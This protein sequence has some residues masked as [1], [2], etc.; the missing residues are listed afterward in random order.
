MTRALRISGWTL[1]GAGLTILLYLVYSLFF[2]NFTTRTAQSEMLEQW[3]LE[4]GELAWGGEPPGDGALPGAEDPAD[5]GRPMAD[6]EP[7]TAF[8]VMRFERPGSAEPPVRA[9]PLFVVSGVT[10]D[11]L[12]R[13]PGHYPGTAS[14]GEPGNFAVAGHRTT[15]GAPFFHLDQLEAGDLV[16]VADRAG[17]AY[18]YELAELR[19]VGPSDTS[20]IG[21]DPLGNGRPTLTLTTCHPRFSNRERLIAFAQLVEEEPA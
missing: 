12:T 6:L 10:Y 14:P 8:A 20:V 2:T 7:G 4:V 1:I 16:H 11:D 19:V 13:G 5:V 15:Y 18:T 3:Q 21:P 17:T 9:D